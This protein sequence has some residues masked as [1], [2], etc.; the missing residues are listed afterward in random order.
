[1][2]LNHILRCTASVAVVGVA[3]FGFAGAAAAQEGPTTVDDIIVTAQKREQSLQDVPIVVTTLSQAAL[4]GAGVRDIKDLQILTPGMTVTSTQSETS[5]TARIRGVGTVG[6][7]PGLESSVGV[8]IDGVYRSRNGVGFGDLGEL[9]RIEVLKGPQGTLFGKNTSAGVINIISEAP[10][11]TPGFEAEATYGNFGAWGIAGSVTGP[12]SEKVAGRLYMA[13]R[14]R[15][16]FYDVVTG[17]GPRQETDDQ[18]QNFWTAR[19][20][21]LILPSDDVSIRLI[22]DYSKRDEYC[23]VSTQIR[24]GPT[25]AFINAVGGQQAAPAP[26]FGELPFSRTAY[27]NRGTGQTMEDM[28]FSAEANID[29]PSWNATFTSL[30][31]WRNWSGVNGMDL[32]YTTADLLYRVDDGGYG[33]ELE[34]LTQE[35]R[36]AGATDRLDWLVG[37]FMTRENIDRADSYWYGAGYTPFL[38][39]LISSQLNAGSSAIPISPNIIGCITRPGTTAQFLAG[40]L[41]TGGMAPSGPTAPTGPGFGTGHGVQDHYSQTTESIAFFTNNTLHLTDKFDVTLGLRYTLDDKRLLGVQDNLGA[42]GAACG[43]ALGNVAAM[44]GALMGAGL[45]AAAAQTTA[46]RLASNL[47]LPWA[48]PLFDNRRISENHDNG[49]LSG[50]LKGSYRFNDSVMAYASYARGY[51]S[52][53]Y[54]MDRVQG[55]T[56]TNPLPV[57]PSSSL[58]FP[59]ETVDSYEIG[60]K[61]TLFNRSVLFNITYFNQKFEDFQLNTFLGTAFVV[62]S[63]PELT[64]EGV[65]A[66]FVW[67]TPVEGLSFSGGV[68]YTDTKYG[69]FTAADLAN[70]GNFPQLSLLPGARA[71]FAPEWSATAAMSFDRSIGSGMKVGLNLSAKYSTEFNTGSDLLPY[72]MQDAMTLLNGRV[73]LGSE[74]ER[75]ALDLWAQNLTDEEYKQVAINAP[76]Q[77]SAFQTTVQPN[78]TYYNPALDT[79]TYNAF[80]GQPRTYGVTLRV[81]Y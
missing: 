32:D 23:C 43:G 25:V 68:T 51:K 76:L 30:S 64:S 8:V 10:S 62:E 11:F 37:A 65:D 59:S 36:L 54:N 55:P 20:Q 69:D 39:L 45:P 80:M 42:N 41:A 33:F 73:T 26:G 50:T 5:T 66:D 70:P 14:E 29:I 46:G 3:A 38:S 60:L 19:G 13:K 12:L 67:F 35:F 79:Q 7:N 53:G 56:A 6:D 75:W 21:L 52:F 24:T 48:N 31:S 74:D 81:R 71:S 18:N 78:G 28:G 57:N 2:R 15:D 27:A 1:M 16:G 49:E 4:E 22:A 34:N 58:L 63:I 61:N 72:K 17:A 40:C 47:C 44:T 9:S 77:G